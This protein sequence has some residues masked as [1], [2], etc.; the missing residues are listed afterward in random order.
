MNNGIFSFLYIFDMDV[1]NWLE[2]A[3]DRFPQGGRNKT[4][5][6][7]EEWGKTQRRQKTAR[8]K[9][10]QR[11]PSSHMDCLSRIGHYNHNRRCATNWSS[12]PG[13][14]SMVT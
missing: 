9:T 7:L 5:D 12:I 2:L 4:Q 8:L 6:S 1:D 11:A 13:H 10:E 3:E 14:I